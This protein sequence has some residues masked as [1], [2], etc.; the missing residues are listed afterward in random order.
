MVLLSMI[1]IY[2]FAVF[3]LLRL[4]VP[5]LRFG[6]EPLP[7]EIPVEFRQVISR[8]KSQS[9]TPEEFLHGAYDYLT[10]RYHG[11]RL[12]TLFKWRYSFLNVFAD[13]PG[14]IPCTVHNYLLRIMLV[15]SGFFTDEEI[16]IRTTFLNFFI[17]QYLLVQLDKQWIAV[18]PN[19]LYLGIPLGRHA[20]FFR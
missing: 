1:V 15:N 16:R 2:F 5:H 8:L 4:V 7:T 6:K 9:S 10:D 3:V 19:S 14:Y 18:D 11:A 17:H 12:Q 20:S 13:P